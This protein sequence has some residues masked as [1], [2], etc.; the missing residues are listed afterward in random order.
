VAQRVQDAVLDAAGG[1]PRDDIAILVVGPRPLPAAP[2][3]GR[4]A[5]AD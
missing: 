1:R 2:D 4:I 5:R 3:P